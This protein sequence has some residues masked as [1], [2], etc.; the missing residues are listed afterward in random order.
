[1]QFLKDRA[2]LRRKQFEEAQR[3]AQEQ[4]RL[5]LLEDEEMDDEVSFQEPYQEKDEVSIQEPQRKGEKETISFKEAAAG[6]TSNNRR[7]SMPIFK[8]PFKGLRNPG[9]KYIAKDKSTVTDIGSVP[10]VP[11]PKEKL[12]NLQRQKVVPKENVSKSEET[13]RIPLPQYGPIH[14][15][16]IELEDGTKQYVTP[17]FDVSERERQT[18][19]ML[20]E[21]VREK[22]REQYRKS[23]AGS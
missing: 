1:M 12:P 10:L 5:A 14:L 21:Q 7:L 2:A 17:D 9:V 18:K 8:D 22:Y 16:E 15:K 4:M 3:F 20:Y 11:R 13:N 19:E 6:N 23:F